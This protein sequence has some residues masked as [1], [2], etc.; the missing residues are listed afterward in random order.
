MNYA[1]CAHWVRHHLQRVDWEEIEI[2]GH[3]D[4][5][6]DVEMHYN[7]L[8]KEVHTA[9]EMCIPRRRIRAK[10][11]DPKWMNSSIKKEI[12]VKR[13]LYKRIKKR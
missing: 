2:G 13:G 10:G 4:N 7:R 3:H 11:N 8:V 5:K 6:I 12:G 9:Q 1:S